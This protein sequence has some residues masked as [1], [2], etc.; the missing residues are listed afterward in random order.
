M[1]EQMAV[2]SVAALAE[3]LVLQMGRLMAV[4]LV[5]TMVEQ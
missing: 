1:A 4:P 3:E 5:G 2:Q